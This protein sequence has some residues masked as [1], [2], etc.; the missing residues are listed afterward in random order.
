MFR[1]GESVD[2]VHTIRPNSVG[3]VFHTNRII[4]VRSLHLCVKIRLQISRT[5]IALEVALQITNGSSHVHCLCPTDLKSVSFRTLALIEQVQWRI[6]ESHV[7]VG[8]IL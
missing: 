5:I 7:Q 6:L 1:E 4:R 8:G 2:V 3:S